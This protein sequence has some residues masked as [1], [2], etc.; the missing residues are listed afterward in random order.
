[1][2][3]A[4]KVQI[5]NLRISKWQRGA[6]MGGRTPRISIMHGKSTHKSN[7][8][9]LL[10]LACILELRLVPK[11]VSLMHLVPKRVSLAYGNEPLIHQSK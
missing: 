3:V 8:F 1:M 4:I 9:S 5:M 11:R 7:H 6:F 10:I 2:N